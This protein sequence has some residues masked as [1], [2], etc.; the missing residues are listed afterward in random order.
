MEESKQAVVMTPEMRASIFSKEVLTINDMA[1]MLSMTY[2]GAAKV[3]RDIRRKH[4]R[5]GIEGKI[6]I[7][8][9]FDYFN[10]PIEGRYGF[11]IHVVSNNKTVKGEGEDE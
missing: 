10:I 1:A 6:H 2:G 3:I 11:N 5:L 8:D 9:Y 7:M 4:D